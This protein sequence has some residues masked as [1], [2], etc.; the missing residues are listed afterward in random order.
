MC[1]PHPPHLTS[2]LPPPADDL[3]MYGIQEED[4]T[5]D[6]DPALIA[7]PGPGH[8]PFQ[9]RSNPAN[10]NSNAAVISGKV[11]PLYLQGLH[12]HQHQQQSQVGNGK[13]YASPRPSSAPMV[14]AAY[15]R[16]VAR[17]GGMV[18]RGGGREGI[19]AMGAAHRHDGI[20]STPPC[21][22]PGS[23]TVRQLAPHATSL[24]SPQTGEEEL[25][26]GRGHRSGPMPGLLPWLLHL[27]QEEFQGPA[28]LA[29]AGPGAR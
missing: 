15:A 7:S 14:P 4:E 19:A 24:P 28:L 17:G 2:T 27:Q 10:L 12:Q 29:R 23:A 16:Q 13:A 1:F 8:Q 18:L 22:R 21:S 9:S 3:R 26:V 20:I 25:P 11:Q 6:V 5:T